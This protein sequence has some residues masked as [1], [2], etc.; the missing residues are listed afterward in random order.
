MI[1][2]KTIEII[3]DG[4]ILQFQNT[5]KPNGKGEVHYIYKYVK[6]L[7]KLDTLLGMNENELNKLIK[8]NT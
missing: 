8:I 1:P 2:P 4:N 5:I 7:T 3:S 6:S